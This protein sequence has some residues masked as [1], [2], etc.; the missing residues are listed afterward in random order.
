MELGLSIK[1]IGIEEEMKRSY[2]D[3]A[4]SVIVSRALPD[5][6]DG[7]KPSNRRILVAMNDLGLAPNRPHRKCAKIAGDTSG[8]YH[9][10]GALGRPECFAQPVDPKSGRAILPLSAAL[11]GSGRLAGGGH[12]GEPLLG[13]E[14]AH[15]RR[16]CGHAFGATAGRCDPSFRHDPGRSGGAR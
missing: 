12:A 14:R 6:R 5:V 2:M 9:P 3:Y 15:C 13:S 11:A 10:H 16:Q 7:L 8:N 1:P 4:M